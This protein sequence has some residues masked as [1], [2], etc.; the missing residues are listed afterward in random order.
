MD[1]EA[2]IEKIKDKNVDVDGFVGKAF[3]DEAIREEIVQQLLTHPHIMVYYH[4]Y[5]I[6][7]KASELKPELF[8]VHWHDFAKLLHHKNSYHRDIGLTIIAHLAKVDTL[9]LFDAIF[10]DYLSHIRDEKFMTAQC[11]VKNI[12]KIIKARKD[13]VPP[14]VDVLLQIDDDPFYPPKQ[15]ALLKYDVLV[16]LDAAYASYRQK[17]KIHTFIQASKES[18]SP[19]TRKKAIALMR[20]HQV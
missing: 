19:K 18:L 1:R 15:N 4:C 9:H 16:V 10:N 12:E 5:Y 17:E 2:L 8:Y 20:K 14:I 3:E 13:L 7:S 11:C 6:V